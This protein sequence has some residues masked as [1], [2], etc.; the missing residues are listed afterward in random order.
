MMTMT[1]TTQLCMQ[2]E[3]YDCTVHPCSSCTNIKCKHF[4]L[5]FM[6]NL[7]WK[8]NQLFYSKMRIYPEIELIEKEIENGEFY[9]SFKN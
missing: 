1:T 6:Y 5:I 4:C 7:R 2:I 9:D 8:K 3:Q